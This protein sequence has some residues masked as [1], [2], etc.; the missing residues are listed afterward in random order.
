MPLP[1]G[2]TESAKLPEPIFTP[3]TKATEG[4]DEN[5][6][7]AAAAA[8]VG[9]TRAAQLRALTL[10]LY[11]RAAAHAEACG[12]ILADTKFEFGTLP[13][14]PDV[15]RLCDE[16]LTPDS[17]R[18][19][20]ADRYEPGRPQESF[21]K[22]FVRDWLLKSGW[23]RQSRAAPAAGRRGRPHRG[24]VPRGPPP[25]HRPRGPLPD[26]RPPEN[27]AARPPRRPRDPERRRTSP[28]SPP[29][30]PRTGRRTPPSSAPPPRPPPPTTQAVRT[31]GGRKKVKPG[32]LTLQEDRRRRHGRPKPAARDR[33]RTRR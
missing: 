30:R 20:P 19:W 21:D 25:P 6:T 10:D 17:S 3:A 31:P 15:L 28:S 22:Q 27:P 32:S 29:P 26:C 24:E 5:V 33:G 7:L 1:A 18:F 14:E 11:R 12:L 4:H 9:E 16:A 8:T 23:D 2:L 13:G